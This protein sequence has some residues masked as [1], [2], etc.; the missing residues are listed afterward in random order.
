MDQGSNRTEI[1]C[2]GRFA[3]VKPFCFTRLLS[4]Y[5]IEDKTDPPPFFFLFES[6]HPSGGRVASVLQEDQQGFKDC[7]ILNH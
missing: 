7:Q 2:K 6:E 5:L 4:D 3:C 1:G